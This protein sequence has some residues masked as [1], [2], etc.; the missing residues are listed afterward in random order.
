MR[1]G[2]FLLLIT[3][4]LFKFANVFQRKLFFKVL[5]KSKL[6][7]T[8]ADLFDAS[9]DSE[10][11]YAKVYHISFFPIQSLGNFAKLVRKHI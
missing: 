7:L 2:Y 4:C 1:M 5:I 9:S 3:F 11:N 8:M 10:T 6:I